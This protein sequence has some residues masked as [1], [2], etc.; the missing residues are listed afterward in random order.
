MSRDTIQIARNKER[1]GKIFPQKM[2]GAFF[3]NLL[4][5]EHDEW[6]MQQQKHLHEILRRTGHAAVSESLHQKLAC[7]CHTTEKIL[8]EQ[9]I[10]ERAYFIW[11]RTGNND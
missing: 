2:S 5:S 4:L 11:Q 10:R 9:M 7:H 1:H 8:A 6:Y 3:S